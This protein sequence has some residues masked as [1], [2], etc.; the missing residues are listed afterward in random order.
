MFRDY[1]FTCSTM[2]KSI[3]KRDILLSAGS[4]GGRP[5]PRLGPGVSGLGEA[6]SG[7]LRGRPLPLFSPEGVGG[8]WKFS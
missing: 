5:R 2:D 8:A 1:W 7:F 6:A 3:E 4:F